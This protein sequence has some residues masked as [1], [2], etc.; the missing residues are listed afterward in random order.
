[1]STTGI[2]VWE[3][4][5]SYLSSGN[6]EHFYRMAKM[7]SQTQMVP[8][9]Y[10]NKPQDV[11]VA[12]EMG[13]SLNLSPLQAVQNIAVINGKPT[14]YGDALLAVCSGH[15]EFEDIIEGAL[16]NEKGELLGAECTIKRK[17]RTPVYKA[18]TVKQAEKANLWK[19]AGVWTSYPE[20]ML[21]MR[22]RGFALRDCF[23]DA[24]AGVSV[25]EEVQDYEIDITPKSQTDKLNRQLGDQ[26]NA[27][28]DTIKSSSTKDEAEVNQITGEV[29]DVRQEKATAISE[30][31]ET[32]LASSSNIE[33][34]NA[35]LEAKK[36]NN[37]RFDKALAYFKVDNI[38]KLTQKQSEK[39]IMLLEK[40]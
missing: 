10:H 22:A 15:P 7:I 32:E 14:M 5:N 8:K 24:L 16:L 6:F 3:D 20:R 2:A 23:A 35:L 36:F 13:R 29:V 40:A 27:T 18:F 21:Q 19:K 38:L 11:L 17:G 12:M 33:K 25:A 37:G 1:M 31:S 39:F 30:A 34:I 28:T 4:K 26:R 9:S